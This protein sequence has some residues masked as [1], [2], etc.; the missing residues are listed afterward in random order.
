MKKLLFYP[1]FILVMAH[2]ASAQDAGH[3]SSVGVN[4]GL[5]AVGSLFN[6]ASYSTGTLIDTYT[7]PAF[8]VTYDYGI[9]KWLSLGGGASYQIMGIRYKNYEY[10]DSNGET[11]TQNFKTSV[12]RLNISVR[13]LLHYGNSN[14]F[15]MYSGLRVGVTNWDINT[16]ASIPNFDKTRDF[17]FNGTKPSTQLILFGFRG[18]FTDN[19]GANLELAVGAPHFFSFGLNY[20]W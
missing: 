16:N 4:L 20:R 7:V 12:N 19:L 9:K 11:Q 13:A 18:Y 1:L 2:S 3:T 10:T 14:Q 5:S 8:Q 15:D 17:K 6:I